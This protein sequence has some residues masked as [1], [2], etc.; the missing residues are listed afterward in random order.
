MRFERL[1][2]NSPT[3]LLY[4]PHCRPSDPARLTAVGENPPSTSAVYRK[5]ER[6]DV[7]RTTI[8]PPG[9]LK[10]AGWRGQQLTSQKM[11]GR[12][13][14][15]HRCLVAPPRLGPILGPGPGTNGVGRRP[16]K[17]QLIAGT[18]GAPPAH[19]PARLVSQT[20]VR[21]AAINPAQHPVIQT[22][23]VQ[24]C[25][26]RLIKNLLSVGV[27]SAAYRRSVRYGSKVG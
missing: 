13:R 27:P 26:R 11:S 8:G 24:T 3:V 23:V 9:V 12:L 4:E 17:T 6:A 5:P 1:S 22:L 19:T 18:G 14:G 2:T 20:D 10:R 15:P 16:L 7:F 25:R 21:V